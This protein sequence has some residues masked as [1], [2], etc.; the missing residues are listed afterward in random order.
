MLSACAGYLSSPRFPNQRSSTLPASLNHKSLV[1]C[2]P[3]DEQQWRDVPTAKS[4]I[5]LTA[6]CTPAIRRTSC[7]GG[8]NG[9]LYALNE[10]TA[11]RSGPSRQTGTSSARLHS[12]ST[13][14]VGS[15]DRCLH[16]FAPASGDQRFTLSAPGTIYG[17][18]AFSN[19]VV[20]F[21]SMDKTFMQSTA[22]QAM[23]AAVLVRRSDSFGARNL[24]GTV[25]AGDS[26]SNAL[27]AP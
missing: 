16:A 22:R 5:S 14:Y 15:S 25:Y 10:S 4:D 2:G 11:A 17:R 1:T 13:V 9:T 24:N 18:P 21:G 19:G 7:L 20:F 23:P 27:D 26:T 8:Y 6:I 3:S 12:D